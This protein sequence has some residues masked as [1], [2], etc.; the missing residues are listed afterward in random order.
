MQPVGHKIG[1]RRHVVGPDA[2]DHQRLVRIAKRRVGY[3]KSLLRSR[4]F[5]KFFGA[6]LVQQLPRS[7]G[8]LARYVIGDR[9]CPDRL[10]PRLARDFWISVYHHFAEVTQEL[11]RPIL[12]RSELEQRGRFVEKR[13][14]YSARLKA[15]VVHDVNQERNVRFYSA[16]AELAQAAVHPAAGLWKLAS[17]RRHFNQ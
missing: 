12:Q 11:R 14:G 4:P 10:R 5:R 9:S 2:S 8:R 7:S 1:D 17:P 3:Q 15:L 16:N 6:E 13:S